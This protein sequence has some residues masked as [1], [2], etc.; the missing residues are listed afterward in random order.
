MDRFKLEEA[1]DNLIN[2]YEKLKKERD[3]YKKQYS[4]MKENVE[5]LLDKLYQI[6]PFIYKNIDRGKNG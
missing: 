6:E 4:E 2:K 5:K 3:F 1:I